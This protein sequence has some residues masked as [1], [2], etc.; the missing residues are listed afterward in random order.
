MVPPLRYL[1]YVIDTALV[2][3]AVALLALLPGSF[4]G[5]GWLPLKLTLLLVYIVLGS[6]ALKRGRTL[7]RRRAAFAAAVLVFLSM[8]AIAH[9]HEPLGP[10]IVL[11][12]W[13]ETL[14]GRTQG[15]V[16]SLAMTW[17][18]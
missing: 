9:T 2:A 16:F 14:W 15:P 3:T 17:E 13:L 10:W 4:P 7:T 12:R 8:L 18:L 1:S 11:R 6:L 5:N